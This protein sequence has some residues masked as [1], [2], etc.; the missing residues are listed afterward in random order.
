MKD[1]ASKVNFRLETKEKGK[2]EYKDKYR[3]VLGEL[4]NMENSR[5]RQKSAFQQQLST[6]KDQ[7][8]KLQGK[9]KGVRTAYQEKQMQDTRLTHSSTRKPPASATVATGGITVPQEFKFNRPRGRTG[10]WVCDTPGGPTKYGGTLPH[11]KCPQH[12]KIPDDDNQVSEYSSSEED[13]TGTQPL[14]IDY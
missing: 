4:K 13:E 14:D 5:E 10:C 12:Q 1:F 11:H 8:L 2:Q 7:L 9:G 3:H 6:V